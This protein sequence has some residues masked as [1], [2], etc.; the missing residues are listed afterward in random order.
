MYHNNKAGI[1]LCLSQLDNFITSA[2]TCDTNPQ[3]SRNLLYYSVYFDSGYADL[4]CLSLETIFKHTKPNFDV[5]IITDQPTKE[6]LET[7][8]IIEWVNPKFYITETPEDG[9]EASQNKLRIFEYEHIATYQKVLFLDADIVATEDISGLFSL[10]LD[11]EKIYS[12]P[13]G[14]GDPKLFRTLYHG[15]KELAVSFV[16]KAQK[17][18]Q[19]PFNAGQFMFANSSRMSA[20]FENL[21]WFIS[22][23]PGDY[24]FEQ[25][26][27]CYY[28]AHMAKIDVELLGNYILITDSDQEILIEKPLVHFTR[29]P[30]EA[31]K[32]AI[33]IRKYL[34]RWCK[35]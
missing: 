21:L 2:L 8:A 24:F 35:N 9:V 4:L 23:W 7:Q 14:D 29:P 6:L 30:L 11:P 31:K 33:K 15:F 32:K 28:F 1:N 10:E 19:V 34:K 17:K 27:M 26:F 12:I 3:G 20:H 5:L 25:S 16:E 13:G 18:G 22:N